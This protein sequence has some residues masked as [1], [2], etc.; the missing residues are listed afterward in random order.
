MSNL[1]VGRYPRLSVIDSNLEAVDLSKLKIGIDSI[2][3]GSG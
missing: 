3:L 2:C 1:D